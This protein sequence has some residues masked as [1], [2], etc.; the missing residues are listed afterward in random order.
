MDG[1]SDRPKLRHNNNIVGRL[2][3][4]KD[5]NRHKPH[6]FA[7]VY[8]LYMQNVTSLVATAFQ[9]TAWTRTDN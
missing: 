6:G 1:H 7:L 9:G 5:L 4:L 2:K 3:L 8:V